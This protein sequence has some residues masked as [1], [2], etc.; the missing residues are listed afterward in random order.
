LAEKTIADVGD[1]ELI[2]FQHFTGDKY[3]A[4]YRKGGE[5]FDVNIEGATAKIQTGL[6]L[7][8][9]KASR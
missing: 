7:C 1:C 2:E 8:N 5:R 9:A 4:I 6:P 3:R